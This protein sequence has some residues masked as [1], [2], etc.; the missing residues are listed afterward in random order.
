MPRGIK[1]G[2]GLRQIR[3]K[4]LQ[5]VKYLTVHTKT[6]VFFGSSGLSQEQT[7]TKETR[8]IAAL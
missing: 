2:S 5:G 3:D 7:T 1:T 6:M 4:R 8:L